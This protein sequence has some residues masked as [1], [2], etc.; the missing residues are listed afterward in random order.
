MGFVAKKILISRSRHVLRGRQIDPELQRMS[1]CVLLVENAASSRHPPRVPGLE[2]A[3]MARAI[4]MLDGPLDDEAHR[5]D[6]SMGMDYTALYIK[7]PPKW[8]AL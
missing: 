1:K 8:R 7:P 5:L 6:S 4:I 2:D 3:P